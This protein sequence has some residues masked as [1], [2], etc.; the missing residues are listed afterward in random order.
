MIQHIL[1]KTHGRDVMT[2]WNMQMERKII[3]KY[4]VL[5]ICQN[6]FR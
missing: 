6:P 3:T 2:E 5:P 1:K 4:G